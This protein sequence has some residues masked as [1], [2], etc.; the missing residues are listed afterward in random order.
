MLT[1]MGLVD[2]DSWLIFFLLREFRG[3]SLNCKLNNGLRDWLWHRFR[4]FRDRFCL[5]L[6]FLFGRNEI[7]KM[8]L[9]LLFLW[10]ILL[11]RSPLTP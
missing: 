10:L 7:F 2:F 3:D 5:R 8:L 1:L 9:L 11:D 4:L 6:G